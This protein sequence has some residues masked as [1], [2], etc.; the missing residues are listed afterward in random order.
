VSGDRF[1]AAQLAFAKKLKHQTGTSLIGVLYGLFLRDQS[2]RRLETTLG[3]NYRLDEGLGQVCRKLNFQN[4]DVALKA[5]IE[6]DSL[7]AT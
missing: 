6:Q 7:A 1:Y 4:G 5:D 2:L 3:Y